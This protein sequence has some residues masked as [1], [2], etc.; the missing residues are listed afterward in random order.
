MWKAQQSFSFRWQLKP[1][2]YLFFLLKKKRQK[3]FLSWIIH[4][5]RMLHWSPGLEKVKI[6]MWVC[7]I[8]SDVKVVLHNI[9]SGMQ[10]GP[11]L[12]LIADYIHF[13]H[14]MLVCLKIVCCFICLFFYEHN[15]KSMVMKANCIFNTM[16][17]E[18][19][20]YFWQS[21]LALLSL[22]SICIQP[23]TSSLVFPLAF[24]AFCILNLTTQ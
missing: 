19:G 24:N 13:Q 22:E 23:L 11:M 15:E 17:N 1:S 10:T 2:I 9:S 18:M 5:K 6:W 7:E 14:I 20:P 12:L 8:L 21:F 4:C 3:Y 16:Q